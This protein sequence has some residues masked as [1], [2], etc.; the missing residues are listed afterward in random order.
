MEKL[1]GLYIGI[2]EI[3]VLPKTLIHFE[4]TDQYNHS[5]HGHKF[6][7]RK[8]N[9][10]D[11]FMYFLSTYVFYNVFNVKFYIMKNIIKNIKI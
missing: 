10:I 2:I 1:Y 4:F 8:V 6:F 5:T 3:Y 7:T 9:G 11:K